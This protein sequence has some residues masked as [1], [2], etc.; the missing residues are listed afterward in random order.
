MIDY[1]ALKTEITTDP[2]HLGYAAFVA[3]GEDW[4]IA[5][6]LNSKSQS[7]PRPVPL[8]KILV[9]GAQTGVRKA[10]EAAANNASSPVQGIA[11]ATIDLLRGGLVSALDVT[12]PAIGGTGGMLDALVSAG[13]MTADQKAQ[14]VALNALPTS[15][16]EV[17]F[18]FDSYVTH[19]DVAIA[20]RAT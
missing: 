10:I 14:L 9:W 4:R 3:S 7:L 18:S 19:G 1:P 16:A 2:T 20:L 11:L 12:D 6:L 13:V 8:A 15:R 17:L 5:D